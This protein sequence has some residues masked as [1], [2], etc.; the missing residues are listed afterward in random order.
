ML[1]AREAAWR[2]VVAERERERE[3]EVRIW[4]QEIGEKEMKDEQ[5]RLSPF[6][7]ESPEASDPSFVVSWHRCC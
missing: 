2:L 7:V 5:A 1:M 3:R 6:H 4:K